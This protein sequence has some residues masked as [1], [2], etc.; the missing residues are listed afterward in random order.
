MAERLRRK[1]QRTQKQTTLP[2]AFSRQRRKSQRGE[3]GP[4]GLAGDTSPAVVI[5]VESSDDE[6]VADDPVSLL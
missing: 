2:T 1:S 6:D 3:A 4:S 5:T